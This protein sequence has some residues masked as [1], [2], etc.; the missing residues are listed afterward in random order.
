MLQKCQSLSNLRVV[1]ISNNFIK[2]IS[3][4][5]KSLCNVERL[6]ISSNLIKEIPDEVSYLVSLNVLNAQDF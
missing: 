1:N 6:D 2:G 3:S 5:C 4:I